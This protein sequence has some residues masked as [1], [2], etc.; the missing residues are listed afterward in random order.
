MTDDTLTESSVTNADA[1]IGSVLSRL[2]SGDFDERQEED[3]SGSE[4]SDDDKATVS[5]DEEEE[6]EEEVEEIN[7]LTEESE[8][9]DDPVRMYLREIGK[10]YLLTADDEKHLARQMEEGNH[11]KH[12]KESYV[13]AYG[14][15]PSAARVAVTL[16]EQWAALLPV[17]KAAKTFIDDYEKLAARRPLAEDDD[18]S[19]KTPKWRNPDAPRLKNQSLSEVI[20]NSSAKRSRLTSISWSCPRSL[21][22]SPLI[23]C[24]RWARKQAGRTSWYRRQMDSSRR[25]PPWRTS[26]ATILTRSITTATKP[27]SA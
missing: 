24:R 19:D 15:P 22:S 26:S 18:G 12:I 9:I 4:D 2:S 27:R 23:L 6:E 25:S 1:M 11:L 21:T 20:A 5:V 17:Y 3:D 13:Q 7:L 16:L 14:H 8:G 10:V